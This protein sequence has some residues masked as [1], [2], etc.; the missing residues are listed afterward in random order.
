MPL[1]TRGELPVH[2][3]LLPLLLFALI[4]PCAAPCA[5][6]QTFR[7]P[8][9][10]PEQAL[11]RL[12]N[13]VTA[14]YKE[15][16]RSK[17]LD[18]LFRLQTVA[19]KYAE[20][21][22]SIEQLRKIRI[23][24]DRSA[25]AAATDLQY[26]ILALSRTKTFSGDFARAFR[27]QLSRLDDRTSAMVL[28]ELSAFLQPL[29]S[30]LQQSLEPQKDKTTISLDDAL[31]LLR[32]YQV[33]EAYAAM[34]PLLPPLIAAEDERRYKI[35]RDVLV[36]TP[37]GANICVTVVRPKGATSRLTSLL[38][39]TIYTDP[40]T[41][42][43]EARRTASNGYAG[44]EGLTRGK[45]CS[46]DA[47]IPYEHDGSD[48]AAVID[49]V[50][51]QP[52]SDGRVGMYGGSYEG[53][54]Q[55]AAAKHMPKALM[56]LMPS[57]SA[58]PGIDVPMEGNVFQTFVYY[59][60]FYAATRHD[61]D[62]DAI[63]NRSRWQ[64]MQRSWYGAGKPYRDL[65]KI[66]G[67][68]NPIFDSWLKHPAYDKY[69]Q[70]M[71][72][73]QKD[74]AKINIPVLTTTGYYDDG[75][76]GALYYLTQH[77]QYNPAAEHY[78]VIGPYDHVRGQRGTVSLLGDPVTVLNGYS[79]DP[80]ARIDLGELRYAWFDYI[81]RRSP[82]PAILKDK[83]NYEVMGGNVW[84]HAPSI[85]AM[86]THSLSF[87]LTGQKAGEFLRLSK[88]PDGSVV[89]F[90]NDLADRSDADR[91]SPA[92]GGIVDRNLDT[93]NSLTFIGDPFSRP[94]EFSGLFS[95]Q[96]DFT[97]NTRD[98]DLEIDLFERTPTGEY[99][100]LSYFKSRVSY[101]KDRSHRILLSP[102]ARQHFSF[103]SGRL[104]SRKFEA[105]SQLI[106]QLS[107]MKSPYAQIN[108][109]TGQDVSDESAADARRPLQIRWFSNTS[110]EI[111]A[112]N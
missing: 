47:P 60:P 49:W 31:R 78:L 26:E 65:D 62:M 79:L 63:N 45:G 18:N 70:D 59:W 95:G 109:G 9:G 69:W 80:V 43:N 56:A 112:V 38:N 15:D 36:R 48:A 77:Y 97:S 30:E 16:N 21:V 64:R 101:L 14:V 32:R 23:A 89:P 74:F 50:A 19:G 35:D 110:I 102:S 96:L 7:I 5:A 57:V 104:A 100:T 3:T 68:P 22:E 46:P 82:K 34:I 81:F 40:V 10:P 106:V 28:R 75:Q 103:T 12:A 27:E 55:W 2:P 52:W 66:E 86:S 11:P 108:L 92:S 87:H 85:G 93:W 53:F 111:P 29:Q 71:I 41:T 25:Q 107:V 20:A 24:S 84:K 90:T 42:M 88:K 105:G 91:V 17:F 6:Q 4:V 83:I 1:N 37:D 54:T 8:A 67:T 73:Y 61:L 94:T 99:L 39:F 58:A 98:F 44:V 72:P 33:E 13:D 76:I 51:A